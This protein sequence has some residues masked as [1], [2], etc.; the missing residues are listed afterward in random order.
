MKTKALNETYLLKIPNVNQCSNFGGL[1]LN[2]NKMYTIKTKKGNGVSTISYYT[3]YKNN[4][5]T[6]HKYVDCMHHGNDLAY[7][8]NHLYVAPCGGYVEEVSTVN[9]SHRRLE[10]DVF[11]SAIAHYQNNQFIVTSGDYG[12]Y[13]KL[14]LL[15][16]RDN[17]MYFIRDWTVTNPKHG[18][19]NVSQGMAFNKKNNRVYNIFSRKDYKRNI[20]LRSPIGGPN[21]DFMRLSSESNKH[22]EF[23]CLDFNPNNRFIIGLNRSSGDATYIAK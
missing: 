5:R 15:E 6:N 7:Y 16:L 13:F 20:I 22:Y 23:E 12:D 18:E 4:T 14:S 17:K 8:N 9:W 2:G 21:P 10:C 3:N 11:V 19:Y 1:V